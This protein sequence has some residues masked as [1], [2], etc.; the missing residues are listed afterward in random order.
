MSQN[1]GR[2]YEDEL[3]DTSWIILDEDLPLE[4]GINFIS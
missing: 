3:F 4:L 1:E 2:T